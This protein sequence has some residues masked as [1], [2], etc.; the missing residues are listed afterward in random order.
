MINQLN[1]PKVLG[2]IHIF[3]KSFPTSIWTNQVSDLPLRTI[4]TLLYHLAK[5]RQNKIFDDLKQIE[6]V[7]ES[8]IKAYIQK[9]AKS[10]FQMKNA[11]VG[12]NT[13]SSS[14]ASG[15]NSSTVTL[16]QNTSATSFSKPSSNGLHSDLKPTTSND[17]ANSQSKLTEEISSIFKK[18]SSTEWSKQVS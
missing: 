3:L 2:E 13:S 6:N 9:L 12:N 17:N 1:I 7:D 14:I 15:V 18:I 8:E 10:N 11:G 16:Q 4:K 5:S